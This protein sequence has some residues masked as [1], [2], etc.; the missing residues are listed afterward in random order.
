[1]DA[2]DYALLTGAL[3]GQTADWN[4]TKHIDGSAYQE[5]NPL[6]GKRPSGAAI[7]SYFA[8]TT[9]LG[10]GLALALPDPYRKMFEGGWLGLEWSTVRHNQRHG[11]SPTASVKVKMGF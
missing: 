7:D 5:T 8:T 11:F 4:Q 10:I 6:L 1:M 9:A 2:I 3:L